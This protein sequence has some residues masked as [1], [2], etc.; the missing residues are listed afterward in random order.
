MEY[1]A[2][3][4]RSDLAGEKHFK[5]KKPGYCKDLKNVHNEKQKNSLYRS[6]GTECEGQ[7]EETMVTGRTNP[8]EKCHV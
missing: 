5:I 2:C 6:C 7:K 3:L 4:A 8:G 1:S